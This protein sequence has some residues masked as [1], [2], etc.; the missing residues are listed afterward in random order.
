[1]Q[2]RPAW[3][4]RR[5]VDS[6]VA[7]ACRSFG[8]HQIDL[9]AHLLSCQWCRQSVVLSRQ[10]GPWPVIEHVEAP[11]RNRSDDRGDVVR[12]PS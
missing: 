3:G 12:G 8:E 11:D 1:M 5:R 6:S 4:L 7:V 10:L 9:K 2:G